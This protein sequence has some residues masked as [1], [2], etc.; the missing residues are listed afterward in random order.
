MLSELHRIFSCLSDANQSAPVKPTHTLLLIDAWEVNLR[1][2]S[3]W[4]NLSF[5]F[6]TFFVAALV[7]VQLHAEWAAPAL[8]VRSR[9][10]TV[11]LRRKLRHKL[12]ES[13]VINER[14]PPWENDAILIVLSRW[15]RTCE[16]RYA[17]LSRNHIASST[18]SQ[19]P[20]AN[21]KTLQLYFH[22]MIL[23]VM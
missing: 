15:A 19:N 22:R 2:G 6:N 3:E 12:H 16:N 4:S 14:L 23:P 20:N 21:T 13:S 10:T 17:R 7:C 8:S 1:P 18:S 11:I 5:Y 9:D